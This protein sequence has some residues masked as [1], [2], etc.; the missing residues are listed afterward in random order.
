MNHLRTLR[1]IAGV[2]IVGGVDGDAACRERA[3][4][5]G[6]PTFSSV[7][8]LIRVKLDGAIV[9]TPTVT[10][11]EVGSA[12]LH[13]GVHT[14]IE[15]PLAHS[16]EAAETL[17]N[18][19]EKTGTILMV[20]HVERFNP[21]IVEVRKRV[22][23][24]EILSLNF[25]RCG[26]FPPRIRDVGVVVDLAV[27]D[28]DLAR[29]L[30]GRE[31]VAVHG[32]VRST[33]D[34][35]HEDVASILLELTDRVSAHVTTNWRT[36]YR[37]RSVRIVT[38]ERLIEADLIRRTIKE[39][40]PIQAGDPGWVTRETIISLGEAL[41]DELTSFLLAIARKEPVAVAAR[42]GVAA[43]R[44]ALAALGGASRR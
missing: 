19:A 27:H 28:I 36:P 16:V 29:F 26:P 1:G 38:K 33:N 41:R 3:A 42:D 6:V 37:D 12:L 30:T 23:G 21:T 40:S 7:A 22:R 2:E 4:A 17:A 32:V 8:E 24:E 10:H 44:H 5:L 14:L 18:I 34:T 20:G 15:K 43:V 13:A 9:A 35:G 11:G 25:T 39:T 31:V